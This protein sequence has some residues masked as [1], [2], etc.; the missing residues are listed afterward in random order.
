V[1]GNDITVVHEL[2]AKELTDGEMMELMNSEDCRRIY[3]AR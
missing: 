3:T 1:E 2:H